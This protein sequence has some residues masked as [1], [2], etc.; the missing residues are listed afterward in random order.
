MKLSAFGQNGRSGTDFVRCCLDSMLS[1]G[2]ASVRNKALF[3]IT[4]TLTNCW[5][6]VSCFRVFRICSIFSGFVRNW[7]PALVLFVKCEGPLRFLESLS[8]SENGLIFSH[9]ALTIIRFYEIIW[10]LFCNY[11]IQTG[12]LYLVVY[13]SWLIC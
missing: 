11:L 9:T 5:F 1:D 4:G 6:D 7:E 8:N 3:A 10:R 13:F 12:G 2:E